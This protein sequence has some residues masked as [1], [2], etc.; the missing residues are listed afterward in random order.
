[1]AGLAV[2]FIILFFA[3]SKKAG[4]EEVGK[5]IAKVDFTLKWVTFGI[6]FSHYQGNVNWD[7][8]GSQT[9]HPIRFAIFRATMGDDRKDTSFVRNF[10]EAKKRGFITG[11]YHYYS[12]DENPILQINNYISRMDSFLGKGTFVPILDI[13][14]EPKSIPMDSLR[15][16]LRIWLDAV[17]KRY[18]VKPILYTGLHFFKKHLQ[19]EFAEHPLWVAAYSEDKRQDSVVL[20]AEIHQFTDKVKVPGIKGGV[21]GNDI[22]FWVLPGLIMK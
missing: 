6:D 3:F 2:I 16:N 22:S 15:K 13:E 7:K 18:G 19:E 20:G 1:M 11:G 8:I 10:T 5:K 14:A 4:K 21:D 17:E 12:P 9:K